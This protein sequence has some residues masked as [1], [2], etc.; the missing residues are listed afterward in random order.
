MDRENIPRVK[1][2]YEAFVAGAPAAPPPTARLRFEGVDGQDVYNI[3][4]PFRSAGRTVIAGR[5][6][7]RDSEHSTAVFFEERNGVW[8]PIE[9]APRFALQDPFVTRIGGELV[10]GGV[11]VSENPDGGEDRL[12]WHTVFF[13]GRDIFDLAEFFAGPLGMKDIRL[14]ELADC[15]VAVF[16]RPRGA[17]GGRGTIGYTEVAD[18]GALTVEAIED[19]PMLEGMFHPL[20]WGGVNEAHLLESGEIGLIAHAAW[21]RGDIL[22][23]YRHYVATAFVFDPATH[24]WRD[25][26]IIAAR[27]QCAPGAAKR[28]DLADVV[29]SSGIECV[30]PVTRLYAGTS[31][32]EAQWV[33]IP[34]PFDVPLAKSLSATSIEP[35]H[36]IP[37]SHSHTARVE[38]EETRVA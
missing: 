20:D 37:Q 15:R 5:V 16:T 23:G 8:Y 33:E 28:P 25:H 11:R 2:L 30:G 38:A 22:Y 27:G 35:L 10:F 4:A 6:E 3:T 1:T 36:A 34:F 18:L 26:R 12:I 17:K 19:A 14:C 13:R 7:P 21:F 24:G 31:D 32:A 29:F 9:G